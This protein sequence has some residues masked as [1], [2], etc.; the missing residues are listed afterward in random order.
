MA[1]RHPQSEAQTEE[2]HP[3]PEF[4]DFKRF[5]KNILAVPKEEI[6]E[7]RAERQREREEKRAG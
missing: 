2:E 7:Q 6:D 1:E 3:D 5:V 4:E